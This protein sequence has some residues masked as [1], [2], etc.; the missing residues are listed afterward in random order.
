MFVPIQ[1]G[2]ITLVPQRYCS[3]VSH[4]SNTVH[5]SFVC[6][7]FSALEGLSEGHGFI[8]VGSYALGCMVHMP[9][10]AWS[11]GPL[12]IVTLMFLNSCL[13]IR[14]G[15]TDAIFVMK[16]NYVYWLERELKQEVRR[17]WMP[18]HKMKELRRNKMLTHTERGLTSQRAKVQEK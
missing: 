4:C 1:L 15:M 18:K 6:K 14:L 8:E 7:V 17:K 11:M 2:A 12:L 10:G 3:P 13:I 16:R 9:F 5:D